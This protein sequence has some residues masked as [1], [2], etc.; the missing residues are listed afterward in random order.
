MDLMAIDLGTSSVKVT[1][2][3]S[4]SG[5]ILAIGKQGY[6]IYTPRHGWIETDPIIWWTS[7]ILAIKECLMEYPKSADHIGAIGLSGQMHGVIP[8]DKKKRELY[9]CILYSDARS[10]S[11]LDRFPQEVRER[12]EYGSYNPLTSMMSAPKLLWL[13]LREEEIWEE[14]FKWVMPKDYIRM[15]LT[16]HIATD[17]SD[18]SGTSMMDYATHTWM[19]EVEKVGLSLEKFPEI[20]WSHEVVSETT[21]QIETLTGIK[22]GTPGVCGGADMACT[23]IGTGAIETGVAS[24]TIGSAGHVIVTMNEVHHENTNKFYQMCHGIPGKYYAFG[25]LMSGGM[26]LSWMR[27]RFLEVSENLTFSQLDAFAEK[28]E[29]GSSGLM[30]LP[31]L[32]GTVVPHSDPNARGAFV[33]LSLKSSTGDIIRSIMEGVSYACKDMFDVMRSAGVKV[34]RCNIGEGGSKSRLWCSI[35]A[36][37]FGFAECAVM[38]HKDSAPIGATILAGMGIGAYKDW[39]E[40]V[41]KLNQAKP[42]GQNPELAEYYEKNFEVYQKMY[43]ALKEIFVDINHNQEEEK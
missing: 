21:R 39:E 40:A 12:L 20:R 24:V 3:D 2:T 25:P 29:P 5:E 26:N 34:E 9:N 11:I 42:I 8:I 15:K 32:A 43:P 13:R 6:C 33:G 23:S 35:L 14:T 19:P 1:I 17:V 18:A 38:N 27:D 37:M 16:E 4:D 31:Y 41:A 28:S 7:T 30:F 36:S 22:A 10:G